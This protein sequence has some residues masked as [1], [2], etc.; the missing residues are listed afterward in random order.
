MILTVCILVA[1]GAVIPDEKTVDSTAPAVTQ[2][3]SPTVKVEN[4][5]AAPGPAKLNINPAH[6]LRYTSG[7]VAPNTADGLAATPRDLD[8]DNTFLYGGFGFGYP[9]GLGY[10]YGGYGGF[11]YGLGYGGY[12]YGYPFYG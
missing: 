12:G 7:V 5:G 8:A 4:N 10:G 6:S 1:N 2:I 11:G 9:Y 3:E